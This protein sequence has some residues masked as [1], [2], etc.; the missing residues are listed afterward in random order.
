MDPS[1][2]AGARPA[3]A[4][5]LAAPVSALVGL[6]VTWF[7][8]GDVWTSD[9]GGEWSGLG[10]VLALGVAGLYGVLA[11]CLG[12]WVGMV[13]WGYAMVRGGGSRT[14]R[15]LGLL[16]NLPGC[17]VGLWFLPLVPTLLG[18]GPAAS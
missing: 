8:A 6:G 18:I 13:A 12:S 15:V 3:W 14:L 16:A 5:V 7:F 2:L 1:P 10:T 9:A 4:A 11:F 17:L